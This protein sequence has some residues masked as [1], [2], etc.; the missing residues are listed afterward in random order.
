M[1]MLVMVSVLSFLL[2]VSDITAT[3]Y[4]SE[5]EH[6]WRVEQVGATGRYVS[7]RLKSGS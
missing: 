5:L 2:G 7:S 1:N 4:L 3:R 6:E